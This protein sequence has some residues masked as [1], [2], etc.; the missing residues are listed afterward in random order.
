MPLWKLFQDSGYCTF[1]ETTMERTN[2]LNHIGYGPRKE[3]G[4]VALENY[5][6]RAVI[7]EAGKGKRRGTSSG[8]RLAS[9]V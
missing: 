1:F 3:R 4:A 6:R 7:S 8:R 5:G 9:W 2:Y